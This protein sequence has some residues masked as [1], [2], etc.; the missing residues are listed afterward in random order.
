MI[1]WRPVQGLPGHFEV[2]PYENVNGKNV[3]N[4][5]KFETIEADH[6][7]RGYF[8]PATEGWQIWIMDDYEEYQLWHTSQLYANTIGKISG[9]FGGN[10]K[11]PH[12][13][14]MYLNFR[15]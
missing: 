4:A 6:Q 14:R 12:T 10:R 15:N 2:V 9:W 8:E 1:G 5:H 7:I 3:D 13:M 11:A